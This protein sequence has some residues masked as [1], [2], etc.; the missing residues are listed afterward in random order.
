MKLTWSLVLGGSVLLLLGQDRMDFPNRQP[1]QKTSCT[2]CHTMSSHRASWAKGNHAK[3]AGCADCHLPYGPSLRRAQAMA[4]DGLRHAAIEGLHPTPDTL[5]IRG[6][7]AKVVQANCLRCHP[8]RPP[9]PTDDPSKPKLAPM[10]SAHADVNQ[11]CAHC[12]RET[13]HTRER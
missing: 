13:A 4:A 9:S 10:T 5:Q 7:G 3:V 2:R 8:R 6:A 1:D 12:H 11:P